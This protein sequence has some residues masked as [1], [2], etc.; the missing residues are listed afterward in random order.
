MKGK[1]Y[2]LYS[3]DDNAVINTDNKG[4]WNQILLVYYPNGK[5]FMEMVTSEN[6]IKN[7]GDKKQQSIQD[8]LVYATKPVI[9]LKNN[10]LLP[11]NSKL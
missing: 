3:N 4:Y 11:Q 8:V 5:A 1:T 6:Y 2:K 7:L 9:A 10:W